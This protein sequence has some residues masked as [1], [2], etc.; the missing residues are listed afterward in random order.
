[1]IFMKQN[2]NLKGNYYWNLLKYKFKKIIYKNAT[3]TQKLFKSAMS[4]L[5]CPT[6]CSSGIVFG[7]YYWILMSSLIN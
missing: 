6:S 1:M 7:F 2:I 5:E 4:Q 3:L